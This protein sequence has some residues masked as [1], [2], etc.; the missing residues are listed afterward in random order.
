MAIP[1]N[2]GLIEGQRDTDWVAGTLPY[3][4]R[5]PSG[6]WTQYLPPGE[7]Q[8]ANQVDTMACVTFSALNCIEAQLRFYGKDMN[9]SDRFIAKLSN[10]T[11]EGNYLW[12]VADTIRTYG[13]LPEHLWPAPQNFTWDTYYAPVP[14][15]V[16]DLALKIN[17]RYENLQKPITKEVLKRELKHAPIQ[18]TIPGHAVMC[19]LSESQVDRYFDSYSPF[20]KQWTSPFSSALK[21]VYYDSVTQTPMT[22]KEVLQLQALEGYK[23]EV[24]ADFWVGKPLG[25]YLKARL[26]DKVTTIQA[27]Q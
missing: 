5:N 12:K 13:V 11:P 20:Q 10:T 2:L 14:Q 15:G 4:E 21:L 27:V 25:E 17:M 24:G 19:F 18:V 26:A 9:L 3:E 7:W 6:D 1:L 22:K 23:D 16:I 8:K